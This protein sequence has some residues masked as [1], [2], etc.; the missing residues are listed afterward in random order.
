MKSTEHTSAHTHTNIR[1]LL[2][3]TCCCC[4]YS[5]FHCVAVCVSI[6]ILKWNKSPPSRFR[7]WVGGGGVQGDNK[8]QPPRGPISVC[9]LCTDRVGGGGAKRH[10]TP[11]DSKSGSTWGCASCSHGRPS[12]SLQWGPE[13][14]GVFTGTAVAEAEVSGNMVVGGS[15][16]FTSGDH[17]LS[18]REE[19]TWPALKMT[20]S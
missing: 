15:H 11:I 4:C 1:L 3:L 5:N 20:C 13:W 14:M 17:I 6:G 19:R 9:G 18:S 16:D 8:P 12:T 7:G 2:L 10:I